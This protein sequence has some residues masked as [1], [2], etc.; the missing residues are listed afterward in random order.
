MQIAQSFVQYFLKHMLLAV[1][2]VSR[3]TRL[4]LQFLPA[5]CNVAAQGQEEKDSFTVSLLCRRPREPGTSLHPRR[6]QRPSTI[7][8]NLIRPSS[9][10]PFF[11]PRHTV[12]QQHSTLPETRIHSHTFAWLTTAWPRRPLLGP[13]LVGNISWC[14]HRCDVRI[15]TSSTADGLEGCHLLSMRLSL[16]Q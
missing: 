8:P 2:A 4:Q 10:R 7:N 12:K 1:F 3:P 9:K 6:N 15:D 16:S 5:S 14:A 13:R 11:S